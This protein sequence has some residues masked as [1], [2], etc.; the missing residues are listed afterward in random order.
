MKSL[1][2][3]TL[4]YLMAGALILASSSFS[5]AQIYFGN[6]EISSDTSKINMQAISTYIIGEGNTSTTEKVQKIVDWTADNLDWTYSSNKERTA[7]EILKR[8]GGDA[9]ERNKLVKELIESAGYDV[10]NVAEVSLQSTKNQRQKSTEQKMKKSGNCASVVGLN[11]GDYHWLEFYEPSS[12]EWIPVDAS[13]KVVGL[14][15]WMRVRMKFNE[16]NLTGERIIPIGVY[17]SDENCTNI[18][19]DRTN[20][21]LVQ[22]FNSFYNDRLNTLDGWKTWE[23]KIAQLNPFIQSAFE[24]KNNLH[25][26]QDMIAQIGEN[27]MQL[28]KEYYTFLQT[29][30][31]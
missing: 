8:K 20:Y 27:Y 11:H 5:K 17:V 9:K 24:G 19:E 4:K 25:E 1:K 6:Y 28:R 16:R 2:T 13:L 26:Q 30:G 18:R 23:E 14:A 31:R 3:T 15:E 29:A 10:R 7:K 12:K 22:A 21:Y